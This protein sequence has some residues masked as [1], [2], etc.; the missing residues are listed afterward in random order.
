MKNKKIIC[1]ALILAISAGITGCSG[2]GVQSTTAELTDRTAE[3]A[4]PKGFTN[5]SK[6][7]GD[8]AKDT[9]DTADAAAAEDTAG[10]AE[11]G[12]KTGTETKSTETGDFAYDSV[13]TGEAVTNDFAERKILGEDAAADDGTFEYEYG[14]DLLIEEPYIDSPTEIQPQAGLLTAG[15]WNDNNN[16][17]FFSNLVNSGRIE[18]PS[19]GI[20][21]RYRTAVT[22]KSESNKAVVNAKVNLLNEQGDI[23]W[24]SVTD[25][26]GKAYLFAKDEKEAVAFEVESGG[27]KEKFN[28]EVLP[29]ADDGMQN[30]KKSSDNETEA[31]F[32]GESKL[33]KNTEIMFITDT[34]GS[35]SDE[36]L[37][38]QSEFTDIAKEVGTQNTKYSVNFYRDEGDMYVTKCYGFTD[39]ISDIQSKLNSE[40]ADGGGDTP[41]AVAEILQETMFSNEWSEESVKIAFLIFDAPPHDDKE[42]MIV[43]AIK[44]A[45]KKGIRIVPVVASGDDTQTEVFARAAAVM[46]GGTY[47]FLTD[48]SGIGNSHLEP[49]IG[50]YEVEKL[51]DLIVRIIKEYQQ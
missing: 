48:D 15:E 43:S 28:I 46:T 20:D 47:T 22:V 10:S 14:D 5:G 8:T 17:G 36:L 49:M 31:V 9:A 29:S 33:Y 45:S 3:T 11:A 26:Q 19:F 2:S 32:K 23:I 40:S 39:N 13:E 35:M 1:L 50:N 16:W 41:E 38:L 51:N 12:D 42:Q 44:E 24:S 4:A 25:K 34:T 37:F 6:T 18:F 30:I 7:A 21:P 27:Q